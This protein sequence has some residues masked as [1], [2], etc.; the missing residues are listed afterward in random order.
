VVDLDDNC[1]DDPNA[2]QLDT[3]LDGVGDVCDDT[4]ADGLTAQGSGGCQGGN[5]PLSLVLAACALV[6]LARRRAG[7]IAPRA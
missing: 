5:L 6:L 1:P 4:D 2:D 7:R 3:D